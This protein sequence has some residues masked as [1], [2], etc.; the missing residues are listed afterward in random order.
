MGISYKKY[1]TV[2]TLTIFLVLGIFAFLYDRSTKQNILLQNELRDF[3]V[4]PISFHNKI[5]TVEKGEVKFEGEAVSVFVSGRALRVAYASVLNRLDPI[6]GIE[7]TDADMLEKSVADLDASVVK[8][9]SLYK[10]DD[11]MFIRDN[12]HPIAF[13]KQLSETEK[14]RQALISTPSSESAA[15]YYKDLESLIRL[16]MSYAKQLAVVYQNSTDHLNEKYNF[17]DGYGTTVTYAGALERAVSEMDKRDAEL[18]KREACLSHYSFTCPSLKRALGKLSAAGERSD[19]RYEPLT[20]DVADNISLMRAYLQS[21]SALD[22]SF[23]REN[24]PLIALDR[25]DCFT[26]A[27]TIYY[28]SWL[29]SD[30]RNNGFFTI[31]FVNDLYFTDVSKLSNEHKVFLRETGLDY[32]YQPATNLYIC[33]SMESDFSRAIA[34]DTLYHLLSEGSVMADDRLKKLAPDMYDLENKITTGDTLYESE[35]DSYIGGLPLLVRKCRAST[36]LS[37]LLFQTMLSLLPLLKT[38]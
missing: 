11:E 5:Y 29:K 22:A 20:A 30:S 18:K 33:Q 24:N 21:F 35:F 4:L 15:G 38:G 28:Q 7:G 14:A 13:L 1:I 36:K 3:I 23:A 25:S 9:A 8:T 19:V 27:K 31:H 34:M 10:K 32:L 2:S 6:F 17:F 26:G 37:V 16:N 12:L